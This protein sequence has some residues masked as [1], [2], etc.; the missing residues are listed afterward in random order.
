MKIL[1]HLAVEMNIVDF[2]Q[3]PKS[4]IYNIIEYL[5]TF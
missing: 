4:F 5:L 2:F 3:D 1:I